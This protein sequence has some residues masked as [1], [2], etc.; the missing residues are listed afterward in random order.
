MK[1]RP[2][3]YICDKPL[4]K[5]FKFYNIPDTE[6]RVKVHSGCHA[7]IQTFTNKEFLGHHNKRRK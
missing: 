7:K 2:R 6:L 5:K 1:P 3:C 4:C